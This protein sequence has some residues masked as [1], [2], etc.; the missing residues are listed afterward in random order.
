MEK[1]PEMKSGPS[2]KPEPILNDWDRK[3]LTEGGE[4]VMKKI[5][6]DQGIPNV[7]ILPET[8]ARPL[9]YLFNPSFKKLSQKM[10]VEPPRFVFFNVSNPDS[11]THIFENTKANWEDDNV[12]D[13]KTSPKD[14][15]DY[16]D[17]IFIEVYGLEDFE[18]KKKEME[19]ERHRV[20]ETFLKRSVERKHAKELLQNIKEKYGENPKIVIIDDFLLQA[21]A[22]NEIRRAFNLKIPSYS[23]FSTEDSSNSKNTRSG[24]EIF[25]KEYEENP[26]N[27]T[28]TRLSFGYGKFKP[29]VGVAKDKKQPLSTPLSKTEN[30]TQEDQKKIIQL[31]KEMEE[32]GNKLADSIN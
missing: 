3:I 8:S 4:G 18:V 15:K 30:F 6:E 20:D 31:R 9:Y 14:V 16:I 24:L 21:R 26:I 32:L 27:K 23:V 17:K 25:T 13:V 5:I 22:V 2:E 12:I 1:L 28:H 10:K 11:Y 7:V 19:G 29:T